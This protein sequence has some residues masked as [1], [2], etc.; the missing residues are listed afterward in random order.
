MIILASDHAGYELKEKIKVFLDKKGFNFFDAG[1]RK[2]NNDD[3]YPDYVTEASKLVLEK[4][5]NRGIFIC[6][7]GIGMNISANKIKGIRA[8]LV[9]STHLAEMAVKHNNVNVITFGGRTTSFFKAKRL[10]LTFLKTSFAGVIRHQR[11][12]DKIEK[13]EC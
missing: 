13:L 1:P 11:R 8:S 4:S 6:G 10:I 12:I 7:T 3:D 5:E 2:Y 9:T